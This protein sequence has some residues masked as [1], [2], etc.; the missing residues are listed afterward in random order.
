MYCLGKKFLEEGKLGKRK[1]HK[2]TSSKVF[3]IDIRVIV[4]I[5]PGIRY[6]ACFLHTQSFV[7]FLL[8]CFLVFC[9]I[10]CALAS[11]NTFNLKSTCADTRNQAHTSIFLTITERHVCCG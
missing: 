6:K 4:F 3:C 2:R 11:T 7:A 8:S 9:V 10:F 1:G 5:H